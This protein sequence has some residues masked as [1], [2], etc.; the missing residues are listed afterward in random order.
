MFGA[1]LMHEAALTDPRLPGNR[2]ERQPRRTVT[3][4]D[5]KRR[6]EG[7]IASSFRAGSIIHHYSQ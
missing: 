5:R 1:E 2:I 4:N 3:R 7:S 6:F